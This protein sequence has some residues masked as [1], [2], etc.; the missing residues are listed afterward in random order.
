MNTDTIG[1]RAFIHRH[2]GVLLLAL[3]ALLLLC[4]CPAWASGDGKTVRVAME[5]SEMFITLDADGIPVGGYGY[6]Y[7]QTI[8]AYSGWTVEY[9]SC[10][11]F[12]DCLQ[13]VSDGKADIFYDVNKT[14]ERRKLYLFPNSPMGTE[15]L[16]LSRSRAIPISIP[17]TTPLSMGK[18]SAPSSDRCRPK[19]RGSGPR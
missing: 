18:P 2:R 7:I 6:E 8:A 10:T 3:L 12:P 5:D 4:V 15:S 14:E 16:Y 9:T 17:T 19:G 13:A 11:G 1:N